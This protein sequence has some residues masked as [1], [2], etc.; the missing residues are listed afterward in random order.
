MASKRSGR[1]KRASHRSVG[2]RVKNSRGAWIIGLAALGAAGVAGVILLE[3]KSSAAQLPPSPAPVP[4]PAPVP[5]G[6][7]GGGVSYQ[8]P[9]DNTGDSTQNTGDQTNQSAGS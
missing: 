2:K 6:G 1:S 8:A 4:T 3:K 7:G 9:S 5:S